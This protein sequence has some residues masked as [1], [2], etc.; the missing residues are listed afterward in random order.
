MA[1]SARASVE[2]GKS[3]KTI[4]KESLRPRKSGDRETA[5]RRRRRRKENYGVYVYKVL[6]QV[7]PAKGI[8]KKA[9]NIMNSMIND[10]FEQVSILAGHLIRYTGK[11]T[12]SHNEVLTCAKLL[13]PGELASHAISEG[14][15]AVSKY[16][17][18][19]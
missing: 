13:L 11:K 10:T 15:R 9:M 4:K 18:A 6:K 14:Q 2:K 16:L 8:S 19:G 3:G 7:H 12:L 1:G 5:E 17:N